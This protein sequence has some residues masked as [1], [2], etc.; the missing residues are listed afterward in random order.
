M[1]GGDDECIEC[2][3]RNDDTLCRMHVCVVWSVVQS[4]VVCDV[5]LVVWVL[6]ERV[7]CAWCCRCYY[8]IVYLLSCLVC[9]C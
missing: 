8:D 2:V 5:G 7:L 1:S 3:D 9:L 6:D 4:E